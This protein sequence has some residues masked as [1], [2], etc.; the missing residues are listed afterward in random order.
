MSTPLVAV[1]NKGGSEEE[2]RFLFFSSSCDECRGRR[3]CRRPNVQLVALTTDETINVSLRAFLKAAADRPNNV[4]MRRSRLAP[5]F[6]G[7][8]M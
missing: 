5:Q 7:R 1:T 8:E 2:E 3:R 6:R 4:D